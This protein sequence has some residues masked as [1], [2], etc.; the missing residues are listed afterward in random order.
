MKLNVEQVKEFISN[1]SPESR[2]YIGADST[3]F[4]KKGVWYAEFTVAVVVHIDGNRGC[5]IFGEITTERDYDQTKSRPATRL[6]GEVYRAS[7]MFLK[8]QD[9]FGDRDVQVHL[10]LNPDEHYGSSCVIQQAVGFIRGTC[11]VIPLVKPD[12]FAASYAA[13]RLR[14]VIA[15]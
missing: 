13:D 11:N 2:V 12:A 10:D 3:R 5:K 6:M 8:L 15:A 7:E 9:S 4:K 1:C 14:E